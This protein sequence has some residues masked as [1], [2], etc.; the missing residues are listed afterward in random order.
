MDTISYSLAAKANKRVGVVEGQIL[1]PVP[2]GAVFTDT[3]YTHPTN[4]APS[5]ITQDASNR[6]VTDAEKATW[7]GS[8]PQTTT[9]TKT[10]VNAITSA[11]QVSMDPI[12]AAIIFGG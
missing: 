7:N 8:A 9:Y 3:V 6:F 4:H 10:E 5:V 2:A 11:N 12:A 1:T